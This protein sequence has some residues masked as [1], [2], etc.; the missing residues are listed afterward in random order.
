ME[1]INSYVSHNN[2][3]QKIIGCLDANH[4]NLF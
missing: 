1:E 2:I 4:K 3:F